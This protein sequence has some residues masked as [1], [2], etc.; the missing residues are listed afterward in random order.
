LVET[1]P[2]QGLA[3]RLPRTIPLLLGMGVFFYL[4]STAFYYVILAVEAAREAEERVL[5][6]SVFA[7]D[8]ELRALKAQVNP[9]CLFNSL[10][11]I[12]ALTSSDPPKVREMC[13]PLS[14]EMS[15][16]RAFLAVEK[17]RFGPRIKME[18]KIDQE[19]MD[20]LLPPLLLQPLVENA[21]AHGIANLVEGG[22]IRLD[23]RCKDDS[24]FIVVENSYDPEVP[25][26]RRNGVGLVNVRQRLQTRYEN[27]ATFT[28]K[29]DEGRFRVAIK[30][31]A[32]REVRTT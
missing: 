28:V 10:N 3:A 30:L 31:P 13:I 18:E 2:F 15:L 23:A 32:Q 11:S 21:V 5:K 6:A 14:E 4:L 17:I 9:H 24:L 22:W 29:A 12:S 16:I 26:R 19:A 1:T 20:I 7:R 27:R 8:A 25:R